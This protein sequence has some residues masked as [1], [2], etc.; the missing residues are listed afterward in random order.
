MPLK[1]P[2]IYYGANYSR[3][4]KNGLIIMDDLS[5]KGK[6]MKLLPG[7]NNTQVENTITELA[8]IHALA[9]KSGKVLDIQIPVRTG[10]FPG[11]MKQI[12]QQL[13]SV[14]I[15][16][17]QCKSMLMFKIKPAVFNKLLDAL[18]NIYNDRVYAFAVYNDETKYGKFLLFFYVFKNTDCL[19]P[20]FRF[21]SYPRALR[22]VV[23]KYSF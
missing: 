9:W 18:D 15:P 20:L 17:K 12:A 23:I 3:S 6:S 21:S 4:H 2:N 22:L 8:R 5:I 19:P 7:L 16:N 13:R 11:E 14:S 10:D 1:I